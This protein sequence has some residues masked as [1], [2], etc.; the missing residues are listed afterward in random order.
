M[1]RQVAVLLADGFEEIEAITIIDVLRRANVPVRTLALAERSVR[2]AHDIKIEA[3]GVLEEE[4]H[5]LWDMVI[6]PGG[7]AGAEALRD[8]PRVTSL[9][10]KQLGHKKQ[11][12][13]ICAAPIALGHHGM[14]KQHRATC[15]PGFEEQLKGAVFVNEKVVIDGD[16]ITSRGPGTAFEF[17][18]ELVN[19][20]V[21]RTESERLRRG[22]LVRD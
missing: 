19:I 18:F 17:A 5:K 21:G 14:L 9:L 15:Y 6:L 3:D 7:Q 2:G 12:A 16:I 4:Q 11:V 22:M 10:E 20:L 1:A 8:D 13:A